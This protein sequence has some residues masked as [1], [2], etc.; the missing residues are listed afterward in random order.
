MYSGTIWNATLLK[1]PVD[2][3]THHIFPH[4]QRPSLV[5]CSMTCVYLSKISQEYRSIFGESKTE[6]QAALYGDLFR[7][8][9]FRQL[10]WFQSSCNYPRHNISWNK[11]EF[12]ESAAKGEY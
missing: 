8:G 9:T 1:V 3:V 11:D 12:L 7:S 4:L 6:F 10:M 5:M 2:V